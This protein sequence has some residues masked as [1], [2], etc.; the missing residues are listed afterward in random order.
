MFNDE[1]KLYDEVA[2]FNQQ[3]FAFED[4]RVE[5][6]TDSA[7]LLDYL[8]KH[9]GLPQTG[10][11]L[12]ESL[13]AMMEAETQEELEVYLQ[14]YLAA[15]Q[16]VILPN[17][18]N[19]KAYIKKLHEAA[20]DL[21]YFMDSYCNEQINKLNDPSI[22]DATIQEAQDAVNEFRHEA[23]TIEDD[24]VDEINQN[25][26]MLLQLKQ[27]ASPDQAEIKR[28]EELNINYHAGIRRLQSQIN[29]VE[30]ALQTIKKIAESQNEA[31]R[32]QLRADYA[33]ALSQ[34]HQI[35]KMTGYNYFI[36]KCEAD[37]YA[38]YA[39]RCA[40]LPAKISGVIAPAIEASEFVIRAFVPAPKLETVPDDFLKFSVQASKLEA[41][42]RNRSDPDKKT[43]AIGKRP[44]VAKSPQD[45]NKGY[46]LF[47]KVASFALGVS[48]LFLSGFMVLS[49]VF[50]PKG[51]VV[52][53]KSISIL[54]TT[55]KGG[56]FFTEQR[57]AIERNNAVIQKI[58]SLEQQ[59]HELEKTLQA[60]QHKTP[61]HLATMP[62]ASKS[63]QSEIT[64]RRLLMGHNAHDLL[65]KEE[66]DEI[67]NSYQSDN[68]GLVEQSVA[69][70]S[71]EHKDD[72]SESES[73]SEAPS[74][75]KPK[76][77]H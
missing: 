23:K 73:E 42:L 10:K 12:K 2:E 62:A 30:H 45:E 64:V 25:K 75:L 29:Q 27:Q 74:E 5:D 33:A 41:G 31:E 9:L 47:R 24:F 56:D 67:R 70:V 38:L 76:L 48:G 39:A 60:K 49:G 40:Y 15:L 58:E 22:F 52:A 66:I 59:H 21:I 36:K 32:Q 19:I 11:I 26:A 34:L 68:S 51:L 28:L 43:I 50:A 17:V 6:M 13:A 53:A 65:S 72:D 71:E 14:S 1:R 69:K 18:V 4:Q 77:R 8:Q 16:A 57:Q 54:K 35:D 55:L 46:A 63:Q 7:K 3:I 20:D 44:D 37:A 61:L